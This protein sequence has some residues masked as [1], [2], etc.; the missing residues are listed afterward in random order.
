MFQTKIKSEEVN[1]KSIS[2]TAY[3]TLSV[4][5]E[6]LKHPLTKEELIAIISEENFSNDALKRTLSTL[7]KAGCVISR[8]T[9]KNGY[10]YTLISHPFLPE[11]KNA[12][13]LNTIRNNLTLSDDYE[14]LNEIN[15]L[16][17]KL[18]TVCSN[19]EIRRKIEDE[20]PFCAINS[21]VLDKFLSGKLWQ[22]VVEF[23]YFS[24]NSG[25]QQMKF[26]P[27]RMSMKNSKL[28]I[29]GYCFKYNQYAFLNLERIK[30]INLIYEIDRD[31]SL[32]A[33]EITYTITGNSVKSFVLEENEE[34][35]EK[36]AKE[37][38]VRLLV[39]DEFSMFQRLLPFASDLKNIS[40]DYVRELFLEK[41]YLMRKRYFE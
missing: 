15:K 23:D 14:N 17:E 13:F 25:L 30:K 37:I 38:K 41:L 24:A 31:L 7:K 27:E 29:W 35:V 39:S 5:A 36:N 26:I 6:L 34:V 28:Y 8:P 9:E 10:K 19:E 40:P 12:D 32:P 1:Q 3:R 33:Y 20:N 22:K 16:Y 21:D 2:M 11:F 18:M 4:L